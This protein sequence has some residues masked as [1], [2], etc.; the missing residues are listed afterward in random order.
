[1]KKLRTTVISVGLIFF[2]F[3]SYS[4]AESI[5]VSDFD[6]ETR[7]VT[8]QPSAKTCYEYETKLIVTNRGAGDVRDGYCYSDYQAVFPEFNDPIP[9]DYAIIDLY[10]PCESGYCNDR[11]QPFPV[12]DEFPTPTPEP[13]ATP[14]PTV[15]MTPV[16]TTEPTLTPRPN[17]LPKVIIVYPYTN[18]KVK[19]KEK[20]TLKAVVLSNR[21]IVKT[22]FLVN[23][24]LVC[25]DR[26][27]QP[28]CKWKVPKGK[29]ISYKLS[30]KTYDAAGKSGTSKLIVITS[31]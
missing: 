30:A 3:P 6:Y 4:Y 17:S 28:S 13:T 1:M 23:G 10:Y 2:S 29:G 26:S 7:L 25:T 12:F 14:L 20:I 9:H 27:L 24:K 21:N 19:E 5:M 31:K 15:T 16:P 11:S 22:E 18:M 8:W